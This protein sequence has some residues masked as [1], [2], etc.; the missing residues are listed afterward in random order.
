MDFGDILGSFDPFDEEKE[1]TSENVSETM[2]IGTEMLDQNLLPALKKVKWLK[3]WL[4]GYETFNLEELGWRFNFGTSK[5]WAGLCS[6]RT[7]KHAKSSKQNI[8]VSIDFVEHDLNWMQNM[9]DT[10]LH[11]MAHAV[12]QELIINVVGFRLAHLAYDD[13]HQMTQGHGILWSEVC[14]RIS[15]KHCPVFYKNSDMK[16]SFKDWK[17][18][19]FLCDTTQYA[20]R[21]LD[22]PTSCLKCGT[23]MIIEKN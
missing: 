7:S 6:S 23:E 18:E 12:I 19:C 3:K 2:R 21:K 20:D 4:K 10:I 17:A 22:V 9:K 13:Q 15:G 11:E 14:S 8:Y 16:P 5:Q 1:I